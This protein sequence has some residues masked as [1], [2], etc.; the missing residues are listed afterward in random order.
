VRSEPESMVALDVGSAFVKAILIDRVGDTHRFI[1]RGLAPQLGPDERGSLS[2]SLME[3]LSDLEANSG[4]AIVGIDGL[5][6]IPEELGSGVDA[7]GST[8]SVLG[9]LEAAVAALNEDRSLGLA[10][11]A[12]RSVP[13]KITAKITGKEIVARGD[14]FAEFAEALR[15]RPPHIVVLVGG[16]NRK[17]DRVV[18][19]MAEAIAVA[20]SL[21]RP[22]V[23]PVLVYAGPDS[24]RSGI[25]AAVSERMQVRVV[26]NVAPDARSANLAPLREELDSIYVSAVMKGMHDRE[27]LEKWSSSGM[28][29]VGR[30]MLKLF[31]RPG[32]DVL[33][34]DVGARSTV[35]VRSSGSQVLVE[36]ECGVGDGAAHLLERLGVES[37]GRWFVEE[38]SP[39]TTEAWALNRKL[40]PWIRSSGQ[41]DRQIEMGFARAAL[42]VA[43]RSAMEA[44][45]DGRGRYP[46][47]SPVVDMVV[48]GGGVLSRAESTA[49]V[50]SALIDGLQPAGVCRLALD[51]GNLSPGLGS[52]VTAHPGAVRAVLERDAILVLG[53]LVAPIGR[54]KWGK[55]ALRVELVRPDGESLLVD[56]EAGSM[57]RVPLQEGVVARAR[58]Y[59]T[60]QYDMGTGRSGQALEVEVEGGRL[61][62]I[63]DA[64]GRPL[65]E[66]ERLPDRAKYLRQWAAA[67][68]G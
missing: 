37:V 46:D 45:P 15:D 54:G 59:P 68:R 6:I 32:V 61:G 65:P 18:V 63:I 1:S 39:G 51:W 14:A 36:P 67:L 23:R 35:L 55:R 2:M 50:A 16:G 52:L 41:V 60:R 10:E 21:I 53:T 47:V 22:Q 11:A 58:I 34:A 24:L 9:Y 17:P 20:A 64:R 44:W 66:V 12:L 7:V 42:G 19:T 56:V 31:S 25:I 57:V 26:E 30:A 62:L 28:L 5:P 29:S 13:S 33:A 40:R 38:I 4:R 27:S 49:E 43:L 3:A 48:G 8:M